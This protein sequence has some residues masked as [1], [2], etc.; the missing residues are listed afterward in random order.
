MVNYIK[1]LVGESIFETTKEE[2][3]SQDNSNYFHAQLS[4]RWNIDENESGVS[5]LTIQGR[6]G[7]LFQHVLH[8]L[9]FGDIPRKA[10]TGEALIDEETLVK[11]RMEAEFFL[12]PKLSE[13][14]TEWLSSDAE[15]DFSEFSKAR[16]KANAFMENAESRLI[17]KIDSMAAKMDDEEKI[18]QLYLDAL[19]HT[20]VGDL[21]SWPYIEKKETKTVKFLENGEWKEKNEALVFTLRYEIDMSDGSDIYPYRDWFFKRY[22]CVNEDQEQHNS[23]NSSY[24]KDVWRMN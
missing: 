6:S 22:G 9:K 5:V 15:A 20:A 14:C 1:V 19:Q 18:L 21:Y 11:L 7:R 12:L 2:L 10:I 17:K 4:R 8:Y 24:W 3:Q 13:I 23:R 16:G